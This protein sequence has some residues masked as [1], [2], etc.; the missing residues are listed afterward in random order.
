MRR[1]KAGCLVWVQAGSQEGRKSSAALVALL[2]QLAEGGKPDHILPQQSFTWSCDSHQ[3]FNGNSPCPPAYQ[4]QRSG[5][6]HQQHSGAEPVPMDHHASAFQVG[7]HSRPS[8]C[9]PGSA[10]QCASSAPAST[11]PASRSTH[12]SQQWQRAGISPQQPWWPL[13]R[14]PSLLDRLAASE[15]RSH[16]QDPPQ[17]ADLPAASP[18]SRMIADGAVQPQAWAGALYGPPQHLMGGSNALLQAACSSV[19]LHGQAGMGKRASLSLAPHVV[20][21]CCFLPG[22]L[23][24]LSDRDVPLFSHANLLDIFNRLLAAKLP[25]D[26]GPPVRICPS[27]SPRKIHACHC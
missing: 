19:G 21:A 23:E 2:Q 13:G 6:T 4:S 18:Q 12:S 27:F 15:G 20:C 9:T 5:Y 25:H 1:P 11:L 22:M 3:G 7:L 17:A 26:M 14:L 24:S 10:A 8:H 16:H